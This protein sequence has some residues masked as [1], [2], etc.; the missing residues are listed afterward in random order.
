M[1]QP[2][3]G[4]VGPSAVSLQFSGRRCLS[5]TDT[6]LGR[7]GATTETGRGHC[8]VT[9][10]SQYRADLGLLTADELGEQLIILTSW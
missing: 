9:S 5:F 2:L 3:G 6:A 8:D 7:G 1:V 10:C 4:A